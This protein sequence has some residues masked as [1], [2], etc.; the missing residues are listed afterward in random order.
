MNLVET[1]RSCC[2]KK[3]QYITSTNPRRV[4]TKLSHPS[5][6]SGWDNKENDLIVRVHD[7]FTSPSSGDQYTVL[8]SLGKGTFGQV[9]RCQDVKTNAQ[10]AIKVIKNHEAYY[11]Q[12][13][14]E[15]RVCHT[16]SI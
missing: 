6:N 3:F 2:P 5:H 4:L 1:Y 15:I 8:D 14:M 12:A 16:V 10:T 11:R 7:V 9:F 13:V